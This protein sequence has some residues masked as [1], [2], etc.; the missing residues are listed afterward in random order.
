M[1]FCLWLSLRARSARQSRERI[2][3]RANVSVQAI[4]SNALQSI[5]FNISLNATNPA[6]LRVR[7]NGKERVYFLIAL[8]IDNCD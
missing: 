8:G 2:F 3:D 4:D 5:A 1:P 7:N 6:A